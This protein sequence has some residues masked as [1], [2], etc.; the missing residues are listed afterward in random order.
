MPKFFYEKFQYVEYSMTI[1]WNKYARL[2]GCWDY[3]ALKVCRKYQVKI[4]GFCQE[5]MWFF[6]GPS[7]RKSYFLTHGSI[8][9]VL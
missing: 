1:V 4:I 2:Y 9:P 5:Q 3:E 6:I 7:S 8:E